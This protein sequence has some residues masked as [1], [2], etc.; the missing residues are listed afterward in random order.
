MS[1]NNWIKEK[2]VSKFKFEW[3]HDHSAY[4]H[5]CSQLYSV[6]KYGLNQEEQHKKEIS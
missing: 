4:S 5:L 2:K 3:Q 6:V 1:S